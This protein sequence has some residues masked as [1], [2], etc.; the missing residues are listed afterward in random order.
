[1]LRLWLILLAVLGLVAGCDDQTSPR[2]LHPPAAVRGFYSVTGDNRVTLR[3][4]A[5]TEGDLAGY[6][7]YESPCAAGSGCP[8]DPIGFTSGT[9]FVV[10]GLSNGVTR[11]FAVAAVDRAGNE[12]ALGYDDIYVHDTPRPEGFGRV[13]TN[14][15]TDPATAGYDFSAL[16]VRPFD[17]PATDIYFSTSGGIPSMVC[18]FTDTDIQ[19]AG[20]AT[21]LDAVD[22][23]PTAGWSPS[24]MA[25]LIPGHCYVVW[26]FDNHYAKFRVTALATG[27][28]TFDWAYQTDA[29]NPELRLKKARDEGAPRVR[30]AVALATR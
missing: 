26:T 15:A 9:V 18:P 27:Q 8:Y 25:E 10:T 4:L 30:R 20:Y 21:S 13:L 28:V 7:I 1:M 17:D 16:A 22:F 19:D 24:G 2:D 29:A 12:S 5:N 3:W 6:R 11:Y 23:A 14:A